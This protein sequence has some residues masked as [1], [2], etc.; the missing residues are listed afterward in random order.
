M[1]F[2]AAEIVQL[3]VTRSSSSN[4]IS[5]YERVQPSRDKPDYTSVNAGFAMKPPGDEY[6]YAHTAIDLHCDEID[7]RKISRP[8]KTLSVHTTGKKSMEGD[9]KN[10]YNTLPL[11]SS[12]CSQPPMEQLLSPSFGWGSDAEKPILPPR[13]RQRNTVNRNVSRRLPAPPPD[14]EPVDHYD[15]L[16]VPELSER[17][18][19]SSAEDLVTQ[20]D[21]GWST[22]ETGAVY[23]LPVDDASQP[24]FQSCDSPTKQ[25]VVWDD[26]KPIPH[27]RRS[28]SP[29]YSGRKQPAS[30]PDQLDDHHHY[31][32][33]TEVLASRHAADVDPMTQSDSGRPVEDLSPQSLATFTNLSVEDVADCLRQLQL[34][35]FVDVFQRQGVDGALLANIDE[36][37]LNTDFGMSRFEAKKLT[38][39][40]KQGWRP[41]SADM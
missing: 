32:E 33:V 38:M 40:I 35:A 34:D 28:V 30:P 25:S 8:T 23:E 36:Q 2:L 15:Y 18:R 27:P 4:E 20:S 11:P 1:Y 19:H 6:M 13:S 41:K 3:K 5:V 29:V 39:Y 10:R 7:T 22:K 17:E 24:S 31:L 14:D 9:R 21:T 26:E 12:Y 37:M 16:K